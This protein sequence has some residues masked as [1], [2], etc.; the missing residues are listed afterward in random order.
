M[1]R[2]SCGINENWKRQRKT[3]HTPKNQGNILC[4]EKFSVLIE[5][6]LIFIFNSADFSV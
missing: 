2:I 6:R 4:E 5:A 3:K 1:L